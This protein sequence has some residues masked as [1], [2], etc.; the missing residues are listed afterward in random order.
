MLKETINLI[1]DQNVATKKKIELDKKS[2]SVMIQTD[3]RLLTRILLNLLKNALEASSSGESVKIGCNFSNET[4][5]FWVKNSA[6]MTE[7]V[8]SQMFQRSFS[9][10]GPGRGVG[11][12][13]VKLLTE[14][15]LGGKVDFKSSKE[16]GTVFYIHLPIEKKLVKSN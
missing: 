7:S 14:R 1:K 4:I 9:T 10:K 15:Y 11:T 8:K 16:E 13:S 2:A 3:V 5:S 12:Y 6:A